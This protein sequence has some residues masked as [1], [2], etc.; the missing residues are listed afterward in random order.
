MAGK[1]EH[2]GSVT[3]T[4]K[5]A[6]GAGYVADRNLYLDAEGNL[7]EEDN[8]AQVRQLVGKGGQISE[9]DAKKYGLMK[10][11]K[12]EVDEAEEAESAEEVDGGKKASSPSAN[13]K[14]TPSKNKGA[15]KK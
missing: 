12:K 6:M 14:V 2:Y 10:G 4:R 5:Q 15:K 11:K 8:P 1:Q 13:K 9:A 7:V 3:W